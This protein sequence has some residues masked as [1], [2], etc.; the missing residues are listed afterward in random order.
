MRALATLASARLRAAAP[1]P[2]CSSLMAASTSMWEYHT[3]R[4]VMAANR[5]MLERYSPSRA[6][7]TLAR[8]LVEN[9]LS[10]P[11]MAKLA[12]SRLT[13]HSHGPGQVSSKS[14]M[15][16]S[17]RRSGDANTPKFIRW[18]SPQTCVVIPDRGVPA[19]SA[20]MISAAPR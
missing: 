6:S 7:S 8:S 11:A 9:P 2:V 14:L 13:S 1:T 20:A 10:R 19:R 18:A 16:N 3:A 5:C 12:A 15:P 4:L 17:S